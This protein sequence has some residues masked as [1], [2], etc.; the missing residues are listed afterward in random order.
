MNREIQNDDDE[1]KVSFRR[2]YKKTSDNLIFIERTAN[3][4]Q[5]IKLNY[6]NNSGKKVEKKRK[7]SNYSRRS[8]S[9]ISKTLNILNGNEYG[10][11]RNYETKLERMIKGLNRTKDKLLFIQDNRLAD[12]IDW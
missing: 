5:D 7:K 9:E 11:L 6:E 8:F 2:A 10:M 12:E 4:M 1:K 3:L